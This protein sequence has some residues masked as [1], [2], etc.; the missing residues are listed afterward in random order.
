MGVDDQDLINIK[1]SY[2]NDIDTMLWLM[3]EH[4]TLENEIEYITRIRKELYQILD[5]VND[6]YFRFIKNKK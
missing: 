6:Y 2:M 1:I 3:K 5:K 4:G